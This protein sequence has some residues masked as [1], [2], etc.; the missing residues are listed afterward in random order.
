VTRAEEPSD[1]PE[2][3]RA[4]SRLNVLATDS[5]LERV[6]LLDLPA[7]LEL[8]VSPGELR[9]AA[10]IGADGAGN[11]DLALGREHFVLAPGDLERLWTRRTIYLWNNYKSLPAL[12]AGMTGSA[13]RWMQARLAELGFLSPGDPSGEYDIPTIDAV[14]EFQRTRALDVTGGVD[15]TTLIALYQALDYDTPRLSGPSA[16]GES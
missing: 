11:V 2:A 12:E 8:E 6:L 1:Y 3:V 16:G 5:L 14:R 15:P 13:V 10:L 7:V 4:V 9:Y